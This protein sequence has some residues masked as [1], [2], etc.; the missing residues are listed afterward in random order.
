M[1]W[2]VDG[3]IEVIQ[4]SDVTAYRTAPLLT[5]EGVKGERVSIRSRLCLV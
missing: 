1:F 5:D 3:S 4:T 2:D